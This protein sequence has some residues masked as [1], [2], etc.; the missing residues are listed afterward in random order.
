MDGFAG[1][2]I[3][4]DVATEQFQRRGIPVETG[5]AQRVA[6]RYASWLETES[7]HAE[8][9]GV[10]DVRPPAG[11]EAVEHEALSLIGPVMA[12]MMIFFVFFMGA[13]ASEAI[14]REDEEGTLARLFVTPTS[15][16]VILGGNFLMVFVTLIIQ[17]LVLLL[18]STMLF[19]IQWGKPSTVALMA[20]G[21][22]VEA[23]GFGVLVMCFIKSTRQTG[24]VLG[25]VLVL[26]GMLGGLF[27]TGVPKIAEVFGRV[28]LTMPQG[29]ALHGWRLALA[30]AGVE[31]VGTTFLVMVGIG[32]ICF[33]IGV[34]VFRKRY[35]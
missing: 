12:S 8:D 13:N 6:A 27:T 18:A 30:G 11:R 17:T 15:H 20:L 26:T 22:V 7:H 35:A 23:C 29:W 3:A 19:G 2:K 33:L 25:G 28:N 9:G 32:L 14:I 1:A 24:P 34:L 4:A 31:E 5:F 10:L 16:A 21:L